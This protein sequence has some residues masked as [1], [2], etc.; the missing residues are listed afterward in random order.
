MGHYVQTI[1]PAHQRILLWI[2]CFVADLAGGV[3]GAA[4]VMAIDD[5]FVAGTPIVP[6][7]MLW[8]ALGVE[9]VGAGPI[10]WV[11]FSGYF[12]P[13]SWANRRKTNVPLMYGL[14]TTAVT[15]IAIPYSS[16]CFNPIRYLASSL[17]NWNW[18]VNGWVFVASY[19]IA[20][21][22]FGVIYYFTFRTTKQGETWHM[23]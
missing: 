5:S 2:F 4:L 3:A 9:L 20:A 15:W 16:G 23:D 12:N 10:I 1:G 22:F 18:D 6:A 14:A 21:L 19:A 7:G 8:Q 13:E 11:Y 17:V